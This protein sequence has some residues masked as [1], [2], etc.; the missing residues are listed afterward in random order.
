[1][2]D[3]G[4]RTTH[5]NLLKLFQF[6]FVA[7]ATYTFCYDWSIVLFVYHILIAAVIGRGLS[8]PRRWGPSSGSSTAAP[9][10]PSPTSSNSLQHQH[11]H[12]S[13]P[14]PTATTT[15][16]GSQP[17]VDYE[18]QLNLRS[19]EG[20][21]NVRM[22]MAKTILCCIFPV[23]AH[24]YLF[25]P[26]TSTSISSKTNE[27]QSFSLFSASFVRSA[28]NVAETLRNSIDKTMGIFSGG[29][30]TTTTTSVAATTIENSQTD[31]LVYFQHQVFENMQLKSRMMSS[32]VLQFA[33]AVDR[34]GL[35]WLLWLD[36]V[37]GVLAFV[38]LSVD[39]HDHAFCLDLS[40]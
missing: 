31:L 14:S 32:W 39:C 25:Y 4:F 37:K 20:M 27:H 5:H 35:M 8:D 34:C 30:F 3:E 2:I 24:I 38:M 26:T 9:T 40:R 23:V 16:T 21:Y 13:P 33:F 10:P 22:R 29:N 17:R 7:Q 1:M 19:Q 6:G 28:S 36:F 12:R 18:S 11:H 15:A